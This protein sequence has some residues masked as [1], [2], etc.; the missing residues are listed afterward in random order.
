MRIDTLTIVGVGLLGGSV[1]LAAQARG[2][3]RRV[4]GVGRD[5]TR[6]DCARASGAVTD[7][8]VDLAAGV[9][10]AD[11][12]V[13]CTP[14]DRIAGQVLDAAPN[15]RPGAVVSDVGS[16]KTNIVSALTGRLPSGVTFVGA[17]PMAG[18]EKTGVEFARADLF[19]DRVTVVTPTPSSPPFAVNLVEQF[20]EGLGS[21]V[22][23]MTPE[24]HDRAVAATSHVPHAVAAALAGGLPIDLLSLAASGFRDTTR[25]A[26]GDP[27]LWAAIFRANRPAALTGLR[28]VADRLDEFRRL[29]EADDGPGLVRFL[30]EGKQVRDALGN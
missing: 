21:R 29:L 30:T 6:L 25:I 19:E 7:V 14:V 8:E 13:F 5:R 28:R 22:L 3:V 1:G 18:S 10:D 16:T 26:A 12:V 15:V 4:V 23:R 20:W 9:R 24:E 11:L 27:D 17:H 2:L